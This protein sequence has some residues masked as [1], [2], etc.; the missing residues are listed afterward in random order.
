[1]QRRQDHHSRGDSPNENC[2]DAGLHNSTARPPLHV[3]LL[4]ASR[5]SDLA[6]AHTTTGRAGR[7]PVHLTAAPSPRP[8]ASHQ[9]TAAP[10]SSAAVILVAPRPLGRRGSSRVRPFGLLGT[11]GRW[12]AGGRALAALVL[13]LLATLM[14]VRLIVPRCGGLGGV[15][16]A[17]FMLGCLSG[18]RRR[19]S[20]RAGGA[21]FML[22]CL[23]GVGVRGRR[24]VRAAGACLLIV[25]RIG[26][27]GRRPRLEEPCG[28]G[29]LCVAGHGHSGAATAY[30]HHTDDCEP[31]LGSKRSAASCP[32]ECIHAVCSF[33]QASQ[34]GVYL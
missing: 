32:W 24:G 3:R 20:V 8:T 18:M 33:L 27:R 4:L 16:S 28:E 21:G 25:V 1:M 30:E 7:A 17:G 5:H 31:E 23:I 29:E 15:G 10:S 22:G 6:W 14:L 9:A 11:L 34:T 13:V 12:R 2:P 19:R 26:V